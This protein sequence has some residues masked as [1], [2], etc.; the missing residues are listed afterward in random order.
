MIDTAELSF[1]ITTMYKNSSKT[2]T[3][4]ALHIRSQLKHV[5]ILPTKKERGKK[6]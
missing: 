5:K 6:G 4:I 3:S 2:G 1:S